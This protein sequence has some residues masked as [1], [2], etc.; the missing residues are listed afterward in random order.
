MD[1]AKKWYKQFAKFKMEKRT[2][3]KMVKDKKKKKNS[4]QKLHL[5]K[6]KKKSY[7][8]KDYMKNI[9]KGLTPNRNPWKWTPL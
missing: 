9:K 1:Q 8:T 5:H 2:K 7:G 3:P 4:E 6:K